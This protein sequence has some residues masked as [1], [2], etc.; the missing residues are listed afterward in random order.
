MCTL[1]TPLL[2]LDSVDASQLIHLLSHGCMYTAS[3]TLEA[4]RRTCQRADDAFSQSHT[5]Q[6]KQVHTL[7]SSP[8]AY[9]TKHTCCQYKAWSSKHVLGVAYIY[10][11]I[12]ICN[13]YVGPGLCDTVVSLLIC[14]YLH[15]SKLRPEHV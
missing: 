5:A 2:C 15:H 4:C 8:F 9:Y 13:Q 3:C 10:I 1:H 7:P 14:M 11:Y 6:M 12:Y